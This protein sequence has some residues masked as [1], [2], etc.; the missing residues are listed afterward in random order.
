MVSEAGRRH[1]F[2]ALRPAI[3]ASKAISAGPVEVNQDRRDG[4]ESL[5]AASGSGIALAGCAGDGSDELDGQTE[6][7]G[8]E[9]GF[10]IF[11][12]HRPA[13]GL[14]LLALA[15]VPLA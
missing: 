1:S 11:A 10:F 9:V 5:W 13:N 4:E 8:R 14:F 2:L 12:E 3:L 6:S 15:I 7:G